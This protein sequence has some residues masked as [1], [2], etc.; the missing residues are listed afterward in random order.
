MVVFASAFRIG[1]PAAARA[2]APASPLA[3]L[4][5]DN[6]G[7]L[8]TRCSIDGVIFMTSPSL[9]LV[10]VRVLA[11]F[12]VLRLAWMLLL[13]DLTLESPKMG[14]Q[15]D[16]SGAWVEAR[17]RWTIWPATAASRVSAFPSTAA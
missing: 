6:H 5:R 13:Q 15:G 12:P 10:L 17:C 11:L 1:S 14:S 3:K 7:A 8:A 4:R 2:P 16:R 9:F